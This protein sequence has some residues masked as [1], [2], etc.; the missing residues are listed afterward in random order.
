MYCPNSVGLSVHIAFAECLLEQVFVQH[1]LQ[2]RWHT[3]M[4]HSCKQEPSAEAAS[5]EVRHAVHRSGWPS[6]L[7]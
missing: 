6:V 2:H 3:F 7:M 5:A 4:A 1:S